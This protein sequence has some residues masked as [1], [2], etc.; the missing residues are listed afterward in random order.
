M[1]VDSILGAVYALFQMRNFQYGLVAMDQLIGP[2]N[3]LIL[4]LVIFPHGLQ[5]GKVCNK[6]S[7][8]IFKRKNKPCGI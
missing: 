2:K 3:P 1:E 5:P 4:K 6:K 7:A 8:H